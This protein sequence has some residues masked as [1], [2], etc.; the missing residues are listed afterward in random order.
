MY[1]GGE[2]VST[3][4]TPEKVR[5]GKCDLIE[6][7]IIGEDK[8]I[9]FSGAFQ[10]SSW[11][12]DWALRLMESRCCPRW[13]L[14]DCFAWSHSTDF[15]WSW[16]IHPWCFM[17]SFANSERTPHLLWW[18]YVHLFHQSTRQ[19]I[20]TCLLIPSL[21]RCCWDAH[22]YSCVKISR[23]NTGQRI[24]GDRIFCA[25]SSTSMC[26]TCEGAIS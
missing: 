9:K 1:L 21:I 6:E 3:F 16:T 13:S 24:G 5:L 19:F 4:D 17:C 15:G 2:I 18:R 8:L 11:H 14:H 7:I 25:C 22:G 10:C 26:L 12:I 23:K 20:K